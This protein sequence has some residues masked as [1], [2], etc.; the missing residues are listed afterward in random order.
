MQCSTGSFQASV[1]VR[2]V[3]RLPRLSS[4]GW[5]ISPDGILTSFYFNTR[6]HGSKVPHSR[7]KKN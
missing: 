7:K 1:P 4:A 3:F 5:S 6:T 2:E